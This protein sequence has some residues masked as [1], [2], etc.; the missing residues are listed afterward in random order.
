MR[1]PPAAEGGK[2]RRGDRLLPANVVEV[3]GASI[4]ALQLPLPAQ[5]P[6]VAEGASVPF[7]SV[8]FR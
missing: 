7:S 3:V 2:L 1:R 5:S 4:R 8:S 6:E